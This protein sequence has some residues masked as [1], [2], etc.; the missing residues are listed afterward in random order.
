MCGAIFDS[1]HFQDRQ[2]IFSASISNFILFC[3]IFLFKTGISVKMSIMIFFYKIHFAC[4]PKNE[5]DKWCNSFCSFQN[6]FWNSFR[7][8][9]NIAPITLL[10]HHIEVMFIS[11]ILVFFSLPFVVVR[12]QFVVRCMFTVHYYYSVTKNRHF[13]N[14]LL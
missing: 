12:L 5:E 2:S 8:F 11:S 9:W 13:S 3:F 1:W 7:C 4:F 10:A 14:A 6:S